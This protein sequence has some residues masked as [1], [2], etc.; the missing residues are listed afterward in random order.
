[1]TCGTPSDKGEA[2]GDYI[3]TGNLL[4]K[5]TFGVVLEAE[6]KHTGVPVA[7]K[8]LLHTRASDGETITDVAK[9]A[10]EV[11]MQQLVKHKHVLNLVE[12]LENVPFTKKGELMLGTV[13]VME[14]AKKETVFHLAAFGDP[15]PEAVARTYFVQLMQAL[16]Y[17]HSRGISHRDLKPENLML[18]QNFELK[19]GDFG[20]GKYVDPN[21]SNLTETLGVGSEYYRAP[22]SLGF[23][24]KSMYDPRIADLWSC[25]VILFVMLSGRPP[26]QDPKKLK[27]DVYF[28]MLAKYKLKAFWKNHSTNKY[29][30]TPCKDILNKLMEV[31]PAKRMSIA[32]I[33]QHPWFKERI[34]G[35][36]ELRAEVQAHLNKHSAENILQIRENLKGRDQAFADIAENHRGID[37]SDEDSDDENDEKDYSDDEDDDGLLEALEKLQ[38]DEQDQIFENV[39]PTTFNEEVKEEEE[40]TDET[41]Q[42]EQE[43]ED[44]QDLELPMFNMRYNTLTTF[45]IDSSNIEQNQL[46]SILNRFASR[47]NTVTCHGPFAWELESKCGDLDASMAMFQHPEID[48]TFVVTFQQ[49]G[50]DGARFTHVYL[51]LLSQ[52]KDYLAEPTSDY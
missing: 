47:G 30:S 40:E 1:M 13:L 31:D 16:D 19:V 43:D 5:G 11:D 21:S 6:H 29:F 15:L 22:E 14:L 35:Q 28:Q 39:E 45:N 49:L 37:D 12:V 24:G 3:L 18:G 20:E 25:G 34:L 33:R 8:Y 42:E 2:V 46:R 48:D 51:K 50:G 44:L 32:E 36:N 23:G 26:V 52:L 4:G 27:E 41:D 10:K 38:E 17:C 7:L 9:I